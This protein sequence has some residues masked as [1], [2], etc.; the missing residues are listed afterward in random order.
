MKKPAIFL[1]LLLLPAI[2]FTQ[3]KQDKAIIAKLDATFQQA[4]TDFN[5]PGMAIA[6]VKDGKVILAKGYGVKDVRT[7]EPVTENTSFA[8]AS[9]SKAFTAAALATLV[10][11]GKISWND[12]VKTYLPYFELYSPYVS[13]EMAIRDLLCHRS[14]LAT[15]SGDLIWYGSNHS[16]E[17]VI[18]RA[19]YLEPVYGFREDYG[20]SNIMFLAAGEIIPVVTGKSWDEYIQ[21]KFFAPL[22]MT[23]ANTSITQFKP[24]QDIATPHNEKDGVNIAIDYVNWDNIA[25]AGSINASVANLSQWIQLQLGKGT[26]NGNKFWSEKRSYEMWENYTPKSVSAWQRKNMP[27]RHFN[28]YGLGWELM[29][30]GGQKIVSHGGGY[31][32]MISKTVLIPE[33]NIGF[34][35]L[36]NNINSLPSALSFSILDAFLDVK[37]TQDWPA[38]F[39]KF[40]KDDEANAPLAL[41][42]KED[43]RLKNTQPSLTLDQYC[44]TYES[45]M[46][47]AVEITK[48]D[49]KTLIIDFKPTDLFKGTLTHWHLDTFQLNWSTQMMLPSGEATFI[50]NKDGEVEELRVVVENPDFDFTELKLMKK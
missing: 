6:I 2:A 26:L 22:E 16:R 14:G 12:K 21:E 10:D 7:K 25:P 47:G 31:D 15:F 5:V 36:T 35:I 40:K 32:G 19:K 9:N 45:E 28:G 37:D 4:I 46:Y 8:I 18:K 33:K 1:L 27:T 24:G 42:E 44:G 43:K 49:D 30:Y 41:K 13:E 23:N 50:I 48:K 20:Y 34:V 29:E 39:L 17:E 3:S 38:L 11:E